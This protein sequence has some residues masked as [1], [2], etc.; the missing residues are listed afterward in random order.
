MMDPLALVFILCLL[1]LTFVCYLI[2]RIIKNDPGTPKMRE[3]SDAI[4]E[5]AM[6][7]LKRQYTILSIFVVAIAVIVTLVLD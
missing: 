1:A 7:Y 3:I 4:K 5:G 6:A 2:Y